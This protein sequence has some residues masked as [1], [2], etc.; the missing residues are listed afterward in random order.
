MDF[1]ALGDTLL[2]RLKVLNSISLVIVDVLAFQIKLYSG[3]NNVGRITVSDH[4][5]RANFF[6][7]YYID[8]VLSMLYSV[9]DISKQVMSLKRLLNSNEL[10]RIYD[11]T[12]L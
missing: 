9:F 7:S 10:N 8:S 5:V 2:L 12:G 4:Q 11:G 6:N 1:S 3:L